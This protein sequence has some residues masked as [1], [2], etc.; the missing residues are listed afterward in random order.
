MPC[1]VECHP[2]WPCRRQDST[3]W[4]FCLPA[5]CPLVPVR[6][7]MFGKR[8]GLAWQAG[9]LRLQARRAGIL[10]FKGNYPYFIQHQVSSICPL[11]HKRSISKFWHF[12]FRLVGVRFSIHN[13]KRNFIN[14]L[15][16]PFLTP[17]VMSINLRN[18]LFLL[19][20][21]IKISGVNIISHNQL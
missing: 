2:W 21:A 15:L 1:P 11:W 18:Y 19:E 12:W 17:Q 20:N 9:R 16:N 6:L 4:S 7:T 14:L 5:T 13:V 3:G 8:A 10:V